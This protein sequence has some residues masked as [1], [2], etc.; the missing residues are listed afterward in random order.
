MW[1]LPKGHVHRYTIAM[2]NPTAVSLATWGA[3]S[4]V[5][6]EWPGH[7]PQGCRGCNTG[8]VRSHTQG[9]TRKKVL[10]RSPWASYMG[11]LFWL[12]ELPPGATSLPFI[13]P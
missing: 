8:H 5:Q 9:H 12:G 6:F 3:G 4:P 2:P 7:P 10:L 13:K 11:V 1:S